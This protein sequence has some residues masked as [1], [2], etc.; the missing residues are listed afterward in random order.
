MCNVTLHSNSIDFDK[1]AWEQKD[2]KELRE[3]RNSST[4]LV[5]QDVPLQTCTRLL[6]RDMSTGTPRPL[7]PK[8]F[9]RCVL[10]SLHSL[11]HPRINST[12]GLVTMRYL[13]PGSLSKEIRHWSRTCAHC[14]CLKIQR[15]TVAPLSTFMPPHARFGEVHIDII[16]TLPPSQDCC[17]IPTCVDRF[18]RWPEAVPMRDVSGETIAKAFLQTN[19]ALRN[20][21]I[22]TEH[23]RQFES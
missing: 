19:C 15:H 2:D 8:S 7:V 9:C 23:G 1:I 13:W 22:T 18:T 11:S 4:T 17:Y 12:Q 3:L 16:G 6:A 5:F 20:A 21:T 14:Q 10:D